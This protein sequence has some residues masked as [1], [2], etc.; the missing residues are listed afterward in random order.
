MQTNLRSLFGGKREAV[1]VAPPKRLGRPPKVRKKEEV[2]EPDAVFEALQ[3][4]PDQSEAYDE[5]LRMRRRKRTLDQT[6]AEARGDSTA[7][8]CEVQRKACHNCTCQ[9]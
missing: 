5:Q 8:L 3:S 4:M 6:S 1:E 7:M 2:E 9:A